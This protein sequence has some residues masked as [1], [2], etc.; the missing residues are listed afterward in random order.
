MD[1]VVVGELE[2]EVKEE[3]KKRFDDPKIDSIIWSYKPKLSAEKIADYINKEFD[4][5]FSPSQIR[6]RF[7]ALEKI[8]AKAINN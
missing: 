2:A 8:H 3:Y 4:K 7:Y 6:H 1:N 5:D